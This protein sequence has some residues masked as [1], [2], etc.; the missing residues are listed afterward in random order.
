MEGGNLMVPSIRC[1]LVL[2]LAAMC[3]A[4]G[5]TAEETQPANAAAKS[6]KGSGYRIYP[7]SKLS[8]DEGFCQWV[9]D[10]I[11]QVVQPKSWMSLGGKG[12]V[13]YHAPT[14]TLVLSNTPDVHAQVDAFLKDVKKALSQDKGKTAPVGN[15]PSNVAQAQYTVPNVIQT[16]AAVPSSYLIPAPVKQPK[17]LFHFVI[18][19]EGDGA[20][21][22]GS[23][24]KEKAQAAADALVQ[25]QNAVAKVIETGDTSPLTSI[26][27]SA[28]SK[29]LFHCIVRYEGEG[30]IDS[31][32]VKLF[33]AYAAAN[34]DKGP[35]SE[36]ANTPSVLTPSVLPPAVDS[37]KTGPENPSK[38]P[39]AAPATP[40]PPSSPERLDV[41][42]TRITP[43]ST[44]SGLPRLE[45]IPAPTVDPVARQSP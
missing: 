20:P 13:S 11:P 31:N 29:Q 15:Q 12:T 38:P 5:W 26:A 21:E 7:L 4:T 41:L 34:E 35:A 25:A 2:S 9:A 17:H 40:A 1:L 39:S 6:T 19:Y 18:R 16:G 45:T 32:V 30:I 10:T 44:S 28:K 3:P 8:D 27:M 14:K 42:P 43:V 24:E 36:P 22:A 37:P 33:K 23:Q